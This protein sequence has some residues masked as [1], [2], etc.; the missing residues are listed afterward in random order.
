MRSSGMLSVVVP[1]VDVVANGGRAGGGRMV[2]EVLDLSI[3]L[4]QIKLLELPPHLLCFE[5]EFWRVLEPASA[6]APRHESQCT[7][8]VVRMSSQFDI[9][10]QRSAKRCAVLQAPATP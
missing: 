2:K 8:P 6:S 7:Q 3:H 1:A 4:F 9:E 10:P 5:L